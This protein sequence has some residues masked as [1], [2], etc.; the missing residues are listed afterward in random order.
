MIRSLPSARPHPGR[1]ILVV[2]VAALATVLAALLP[3][4]QALAGAAAQAAS[5]PVTTYTGLTPAQR[6]D[7]L[8]IARDSWKFYGADIDQATNLPMDNLTLAGGA[9][10]PTG[11]GRY[12]SAANIGV[13]SGR[14]W[15]PGTSA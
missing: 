10:A 14:S 3:A 15:P 11:Y 9:A 13:Y 5:R 2:L 4:R 6:A 12:T 1:T 7:L 8:S